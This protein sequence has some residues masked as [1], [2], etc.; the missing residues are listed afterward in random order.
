MQDVAQYRAATARGMPGA[1][2][3]PAGARR[4]VTGI[5]PTTER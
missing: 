3:D 5:L 2:D 1:R 4:V